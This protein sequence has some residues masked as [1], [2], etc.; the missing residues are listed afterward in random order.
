MNKFLIIF[1]LLAMTFS[2]TQSHAGNL[3]KLGGSVRFTG[4]SVG[5]IPEGDV[6]SDADPLWLTQERLRV[7]MQAY[8]TDTLSIEIQVDGTFTAGSFPTGEFAFVKVEDAQDHLS[9]GIHRGFATLYAGNWDLKLG[10]QRIS[11]GVGQ[12]YN[13]SNIFSHVE[14]ADPTQELAGIPAFMLRHPLGPLGEFTAVIALDAEDD[15]PQTGFYGVMNALQTDWGLVAS[16]AQR[17]NMLLLGW[18]IKGAQEI[19]YWS[20]GRWARTL[21]QADR[22]T[23]HAETGIAYTIPLGLRSLYVS[24][25]YYVRSEGTQNPRPSLIPVKQKSAVE[26]GLLGSH[27]LYLTTSL[28]IVPEMQWQVAGLTSL[29]QASAQLFSFFNMSWIDNLDIIVGAVAP[30]GRVDSE[31]IPDYRPLNISSRAVAAFAMVELYY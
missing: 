6:G 26:D 14:F 3:V 17:G 19:G 8:P 12:L 7:E 22:G 20:E 9:L 5:T 25:E 4:L 30:I 1:C 24:A 18:N 27:Y 28:D 10:I 23:V 16:W 21:D 15:S 11:W 29:T 31:F 2:A 13:P